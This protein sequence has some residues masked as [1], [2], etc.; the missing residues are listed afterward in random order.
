[1]NARIRKGYGSNV[2]C[3]IRVTVMKYRHVRQH[4]VDPL[5]SP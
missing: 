3:I 4:R 5:K 1:V 2:N